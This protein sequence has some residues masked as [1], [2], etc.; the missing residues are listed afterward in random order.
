MQA[1]DWLGQVNDFA[2]SDVTEMYCRAYGGSTGEC[3]VEDD[4]VKP[5]PAGAS[6]E[7]ASKPAT[8]SP[9]LGENKLSPRP[10]VKTSMVEQDPREAVESMPSEASAPI[11]SEA[12]PVPK[13]ETDMLLSDALSVAPKKVDGSARG[14]LVPT[15]NNYTKDQDDSPTPTKPP[16]QSILPMQSHPIP[17]LKTPSPRASPK[18]AL[19]TLRVQTSFI[20]QPV[21]PKPRRTETPIPVHAPKPQRKNQ[22]KSG[23]GSSNQPVSLNADAVPLSAVVAPQP[24]NG[25]E[26]NTD[27]ISIEIHANDDEDDGPSTHDEADLTDF[28]DADLT[29]R[30]PPSATCGRT[31]VEPM[32]SGIDEILGSSRRRRAQATR[33]GGIV[34]LP[35]SSPS[36]SS[37]HRRRS[38]SLVLPLQDKV[39]GP[40]TPNGYDDISPITRGEWGFLMVSDPFR[41]KTA[42]VS[43]V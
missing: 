12:P 27:D 6:V 17:F 26:A 32:W 1:Y 39:A 38:S 24:V 5:T 16:V 9:I 28:E 35:P 41:T 34:M 19:P 13:N 20:T 29:A 30:P 3:G 2:L 43:C 11:I 22:K 15:N 10:V 36:S 33:R 40:A 42:A 21:K 4:L 18:A 23:S 14:L 37:H 7:P 8:P 31:P 25:R